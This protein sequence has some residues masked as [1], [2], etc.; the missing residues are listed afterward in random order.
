MGSRVFRVTKLN[1][2]RPWLNRQIALDTSNS[3]TKAMGRRSQSL[4]KAHGSASLRA[5][6]EDKLGTKWITEHTGC[7]NYYHFLKT[8]SKVPPTRDISKYGKI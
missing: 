6:Q 1:K 2:V 8:I 3:Q 4:A 7:E 5:H